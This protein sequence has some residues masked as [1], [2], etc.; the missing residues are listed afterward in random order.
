MSISNVLQF[1]PSGRNHGFH[2]ASIPRLT[3]S[4]EH[5]LL[6]GA[7]AAFLAGSIGVALYALSVL[8]N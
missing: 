4:Q 1:A 8:G 5:R 7:M 2:G 6:V 3:S